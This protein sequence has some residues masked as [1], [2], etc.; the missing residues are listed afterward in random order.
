MLEPSAGDPPGSP[1]SS[2]VVSSSLWPPC[3]SEMTIIIPCVALATPR[4]GRAGQ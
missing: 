3:A 4:L 2:L 1:G